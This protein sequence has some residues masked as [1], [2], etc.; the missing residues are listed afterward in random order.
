MEQARPRIGE[1]D[2][3]GLEIHI[4]KL[5]SMMSFNAD[6][7]HESKDWPYIWR[8]GNAKTAEKALPTQE[9]LAARKARTRRF[10][11]ISLWGAAS[12]LMYLALFLNQEIVTGYFTRGG[13]FALAIVGTAL[14]FALVHGTFAG[15]I[16]EDLNC[17]TAN[18]EKV[19]H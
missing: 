3:K 12:L 4:K 14:S 16:L 9:E 8:K 6:A 19:E 11:K 13:F 7:I 15:Q 5:A 1:L 17:K 10:V 18:R 2:T